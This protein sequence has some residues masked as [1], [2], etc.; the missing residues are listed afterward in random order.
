MESGWMN[1]LQSIYIYI[2]IYIKRT[3]Y[4]NI[5]SQF[6]LYLL[7]LSMLTKAIHNASNFL[8]G[9]LTKSLN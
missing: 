3:Y 7:V 6:F 1:K 9:G 2:Y 5:Q 4:E 8:F